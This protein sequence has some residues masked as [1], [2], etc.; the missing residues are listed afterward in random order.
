MKRHG[1]G[2]KDHKRE[3]NSRKWS[4]NKFIIERNILIFSG[5]FSLKNL[6]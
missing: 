2:E 4:K 1:K 6:G 5:K 3:E